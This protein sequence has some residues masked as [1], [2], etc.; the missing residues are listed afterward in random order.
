MTENRLLIIFAK[1][2]EKGRVKT[3][4]ADTLGEDKALAIYQS[5]LDYTLDVAGSTESDRELWLSRYIPER[6]DLGIAGFKLK[7]QRGGDLG[8]RMSHSFQQAFG[9]G[10]RK[11]VIIGSDCAELTSEILEQAFEKLDSHNLVL[12]P[13]EDG[14]YYLLGMR[15][16]DGELFEDICWS[17]K[18]VF[19]QTVES[20]QKL[21]LDIGFLPELN[22]VDNE[23]DWQSAKDNL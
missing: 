17:T 10:Y 11:V 2:P 13:S 18:K 22:D 15:Q 12:G 5:L 14:G 19:R 7:L 23:A 3:R 16:Y 9:N 6:S 20:A 21:N 1:N 4:L 8:E